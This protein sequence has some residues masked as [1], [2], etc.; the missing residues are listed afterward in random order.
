LAVFLDTEREE[1]SGERERSPRERGQ[2]RERQRRSS[3]L[4]HDELQLDM[5][6]S[7]S[8]REEKRSRDSL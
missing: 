6:G 5:L 4:V 3:S 8:S 2:G 1:R 7:V